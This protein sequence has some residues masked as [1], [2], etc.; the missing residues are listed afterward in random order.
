MKR[1]WLFLVRCVRTKAGGK[2]VELA[3]HVRGGEN[4]DHARKFNRLSAV[5]L[6]DP[7]MRVGAAQNS[8]VHHPGAMNIADEFS[9]SAQ[10]PKVFFALNS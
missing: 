9:N 6:D 10:K 2:I 1:R 4:A 3:R 5:Y 8:G 7:R